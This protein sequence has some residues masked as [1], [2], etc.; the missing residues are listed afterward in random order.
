MTALQERISQTKVQEDLKRIDI[1]SPDP[2][3]AHFVLGSQ[4]IPEFIQKAP[5]NTDDNALL[6][7]S[8]PKT[9]YQ[10]TSEEN[11]KELSKYSRGP[12]PY[13]RPGKDSRCRGWL[14]NNATDS[15]RTTDK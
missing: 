8:A 7:F 4:E 2:L 3:L 9:L 6:E 15:K 14:R 13:L 10:D 5:F 12:T 11:F 1:R